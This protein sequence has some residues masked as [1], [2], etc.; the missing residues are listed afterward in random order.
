TVLNEFSFCLNNRAVFLGKTSVLDVTYLLRFL[1]RCAA[2]FARLP[3]TAMLHHRRLWAFVWS[4]N[5]KVQTDPRQARISRKSTE[6]MRSAADSAKGC[7]SSSEL[8]QRRTR[9]SCNP[10]STPVAPITG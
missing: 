4:R 3:Q 9:R 7:N 6:Q 8:S 1:A 10:C 2:A 5:N